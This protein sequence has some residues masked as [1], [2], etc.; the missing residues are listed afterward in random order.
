MKWEHGM[1]EMNCEG[2]HMK[3]KSYSLFKMTDGVRAS[4]RGKMTV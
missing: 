3:T 2:K 1:Q 4:N